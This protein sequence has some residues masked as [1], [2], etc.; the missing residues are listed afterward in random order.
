VRAIKRNIYITV[1][2]ILLQMLQ[3]YNKYRVLKVFLDDPLPEFGFQLREI[4]RK[5]KLAPI[6]VK[7]YLGEL[8][9]G[10]LIVKISR[11]KGHF[12]LYKANRES[13]KFRTAKKVFAVSELHESGTVD[14]IYDSLL[15]NAII[16]FGSA[17]KGEDLKESDMDIY[18][19]CSEKQISLE[20]Y[21]KKIG[22]K[23]SLIIEKDFGRLS[24][25]L[26]NNII[27][28]ILL[29]GYLKVF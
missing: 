28:G 29:K 16:L 8:L 22:K 21:E 7:R 5:S 15:P 2:I 20:K 11:G 19:Q 27:N 13:E 24:S 12:P 4:G 14:Y 26:K 10:G 17:S 18:C 23:I 3:N 6:S 9:K 25:E 1:V